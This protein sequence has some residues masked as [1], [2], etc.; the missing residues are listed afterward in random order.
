MTKILVVEG[1]FGELA[2]YARRIL[3][4]FL[5]SLPERYGKEYRVERVD[6][7]T[8]QLSPLNEAAFKKRNELLAAKK[9]SDPA[10]AYARQFA[11][12]DLIVIAA[13]EYYMNIPAKLS[14]YLEHAICPG[15][16]FVRRGEGSFQSKCEAQA[17][18]Y[19]AA[20]GM[21]TQDQWAWQKTYFEDV[22]FRLRMGF[23]MASAN[24]LYDGSPEGREY[25]VKNACSRA[26]RIAEELNQ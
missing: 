2:P 18:V 3:D 25:Y 15:I 1:C 9:Y 23:K 11:E 7:N 4:A 20:R 8:I 17:L 14:T 26:K 19:L 22:A 13:T 12:A 24:C 10:F 21:E 16:A 5:S 6:L